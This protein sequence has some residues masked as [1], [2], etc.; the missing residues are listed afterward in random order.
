MGVK[1]LNINKMKIE[2]RYNL[3]ETNPLSRTTSVVFMRNKHG[4]SLFVV[5]VPGQTR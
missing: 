2:P 5:V 3:L 1:Y 4:D